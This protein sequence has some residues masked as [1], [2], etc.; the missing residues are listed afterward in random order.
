[1]G[2]T[3]KTSENAVQSYCYI[4]IWVHDKVDREIESQGEK[5][6]AVSEWLKSNTNFKSV[7]VNLSR[8]SCYCILQKY[9]FLTEDWTFILGTVRNSGHETRSGDC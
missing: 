2:K 7:V 3:D 6:T 8:N 5:L 9:L 4:V 1:M